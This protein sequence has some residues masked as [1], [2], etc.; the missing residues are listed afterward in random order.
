MSNLITI[1]EDEKYLRQI[2]KEVKFDDCELESDIKKL[3]EFLDSS[4]IGY[5]LASIQIGI[6][7]RI[8]C[9][10]STEESGRADDDYTVL[11][12]PKIISMKGRTEFWEACFSCGTS[13]LGLVER[14]YAI[15]VEYYD[16]KGNKYI[17]DYE[18][19]VSTVLCHEI[20]HLDGVFHLDKAKDFVTL[21]LEGRLEKRKQ[22]PYKI[23]SKEGCFEYVKSYPNKNVWGTK[24]NCGYD[25]FAYVSEHPWMDVDVTHTVK[26]LKCGKDYVVTRDMA[27][28]FYNQKIFDCFKPVKGKVLEIGCGGGLLTKYLHFK[29]DVD[30]VCGIDIDEGNS[31]CDDYICMDLNELDVDKLERYDYVVCRDVL[32]YLQDLDSVFSKLSKVS[33]KVVLLN[34]YNPNHK[35]CHNKTDI[36]DVYMTVKKYYKDVE[37]EY[38]VFYK[39]GYLIRSK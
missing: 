33:D 18:G 27:E 1:M 38:P 19:F 8:I 24:C 5:A 39:H 32:M 25:V 16:E 14:P 20:D 26:C 11:I 12:N 22:E 37:L 34:W 35:N 13:N 29:A 28:R 6:P 10:K 36:E 31:F 3:K 15:T 2:S 21:E 9:I 4:S 30:Y 7:K 17:K 23:Y